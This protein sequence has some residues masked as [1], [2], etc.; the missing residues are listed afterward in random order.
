M[1]YAV[2]SDIHANLEALLAFFQR[3]TEL[4]I[5]EVICLGDIVG[6]NASPNECVDVL[7]SKNARCLM[8]N[9]DIRAAG[10]KHA[11][12]FNQTAEAALA[13]TIE[14]LT[15]ENKAFLKSLPLTQRV[16]NL[17]F[18]MHGAVNDIDEYVRGRQAATTQINLVKEL[19]LNLCFFGHTHIGAVYA[20]CNGSVDA[21]EEES[22]KLR[23][24]CA[25]LINPGSIG[26]PRD[27]NPMPSF[28]VYDS[29]TR[30]VEFHR[31]DYDVNSAVEK[32]ISAGLP[33]RLAERLKLGW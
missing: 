16:D 22:F 5:N 4:K 23:G 20:E 9:H 32:I 3:A 2:I 30:I 28:L 15:E 7:R 8:G 26:Q 33:K 27:S 19:G 31:I 24:D 12:D 1:R 29:R 21:V 6:Y 18:A 25:Y 11:G 10:L 13:W 17:F 14:N